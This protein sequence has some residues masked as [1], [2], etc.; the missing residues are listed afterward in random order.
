MAVYHGRQ[1]VIY[2]STTG[3]GNASQVIKMNEW[4]IDRSTDT[5][6]V[7]SFG[8]ANKT[9]VQ[10]LPDLKGTFSGFWDESESKPFTASNSN[11]GCKLYLYPAS[12]A[13]SKYWYGPAWLSVSMDVSVSDAVK[14]AGSFSAN[15]SWGN[16]F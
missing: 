10:G 14:L 15:G 4:S 9:Y 11:D 5:V 12:S 8:D 6:E 1:G 13:T 3:S 16:T 2:L 7:T